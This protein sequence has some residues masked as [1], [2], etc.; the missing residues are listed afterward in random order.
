[1]DTFSHGA[2]T[3]PRS[4]TAHTDVGLKSSA[5]VNGSRFGQPNGSVL[6][7]LPPQTPILGSVHQ[8]NGAPMGSQA[9]TMPMGYATQA[10]QPLL[11]QAPNG[12]KVVYHA[13]SHQNVAGVMNTS[14]DSIAMSLPAGQVLSHP[15]GGGGGFD[16]SQQQQ[17]VSS[18]RQPYQQHP[19]QQPSRPE[20]TVMMGQPSPALSR[21][22][23]PPDYTTDWS[24]VPPT[25][26]T[27]QPPRP[28]GVP[29]S[30]KLVPGRMTKPAGGGGNVPSTAV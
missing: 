8:L 23:A 10:Q 12:P 9:T 3:L 6:N 13:Q 15:R 7:S 2:G 27:P 18:G 21:K 11:Q 16:P 14:D 4:E 1:M 22:L 20:S 28:M 5:S 25:V 24:D 19:Q 29:R 26:A 17:F 30:G